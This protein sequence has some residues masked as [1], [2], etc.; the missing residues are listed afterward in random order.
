MEVLSRLLRKT[1]LETFSSRSVDVDYFLKGLSVDP[2]ELA[3]LRET[4]LATSTDTYRGLLKE[5]LGWSIMM[6]DALESGMR[7][8]ADLVFE[9]IKTLDKD[10]LE[11]EGFHNVPKSPARAIRGGKKKCGWCA[12]NAAGVAL[13]VDGQKTYLSCGKM[14]HGEG[15]VSLGTMGKEIWTLQA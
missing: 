4:R 3:L 15:F 6:N 1:G 12:T 2:E 10:I 13:D 9:H 7:N 14:H 8:E 5:R 11:R